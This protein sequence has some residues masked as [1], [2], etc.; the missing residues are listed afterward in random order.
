ME[1]LD[2]EDYFLNTEAYWPASHQRN[3]SKL[4]R[5]IAKGCG[6]KNSSVVK[7]Y[8]RDILAIAKV[9]QK[10]FPK[11]VYIVNSG[12]S[13][14]H[15][16]EAMLGFLP[17]FYN[18]GEI[19]LPKQIMG[20]LAKKNNTD[21]SIFIDALYLTHCGGIYSDS[22]VASL[23]NSAHLADHKKISEFSLNKK[24]I[25]LL[26][27]PV[28][29]AMSRTF[30]KEEYKKDVAPKASDLDYLERNCLYLERFYGSLDIKSFDAVLK[31]EDL[32]KKPYEEMRQ[33][34]DILG[35]KPSSDAIRKAVEKTS[36]SA[37]K[38]SIAKGEAPVTNIFTGQRDE[39]GW[40]IEYAEN[41]LGEIS[42]Q[43]G[44]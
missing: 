7:S 12:S 23:S 3:A 21:A 30:R 22:L 9:R 37:V 41:R 28:D 36:E 5:F 34:V 13:G 17:E 25:L 6:S 11:H 32:R 38:E 8:V 24:I 2:L 15:W 10:F 43:L 1:N 29:V 4:Q 35:L 20:A 27:N 42:K 14:S 19:Y 18:G 33:L 40:A 31:Y 44:Y 39:M 26:R 16:L